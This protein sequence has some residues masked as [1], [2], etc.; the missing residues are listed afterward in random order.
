MHGQ[1]LFSA[2]F[3]LIYSIP[4]FS[5]IILSKCFLRFFETRYHL[6]RFSS[7]H[8]QFMGLNDITHIYV[9]TIYAVY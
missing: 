2:L 6:V 9:C 4:A 3:F 7:F 8:L 5:L 1:L